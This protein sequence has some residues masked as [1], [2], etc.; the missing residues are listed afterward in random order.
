MNFHTLLSGGSLLLAVAACSSVPVTAP[1]APTSAS[2]LAQQGQTNSRKGLPPQTLAPGECG[3]FLWTRREQPS[4]VFFSR[5][6]TESA[7]VWLDGQEVDAQRTSFGGDIFGQELTE[8]GFSLPDGKEV[9]LNL[10]PG[11]LLV[12]GQ[13]I[14]E[15]TM[16]VIDLEGWKTMTPV[17]GVSVCQPQT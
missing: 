2:A 13:R 1:E 11:E 14:P 8:Q 17:A 7:S 12:G 6:G 16:T 15:A 3:L 5:T 4:F 10:S 9:Q